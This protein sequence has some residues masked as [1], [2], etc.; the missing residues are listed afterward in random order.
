M[1]MLG[2]PDARKDRECDMEDQ[3]CFIDESH[4]DGINRSSFMEAI[5]HRLRHR[6]Q[7][8]KILGDHSTERW[9]RV[10]AMALCLIGTCLGVAEAQTV[11]LFSI[12][13]PDVSP[14]AIT[15]GPDGNL[16]FTERA[17]QIGRITPVGVISEF[18]AGITPGGGPYGITSGPDGNLWFTEY[19]GNRIGR[20]T[21]AGVVT[22]FSAGITPNSH[23]VSITTGPDG[24]L[25]FTE[26]SGRIGRI[27]PAGVV[28]EFSAGITPN[29]GLFAITAG[30]DGNLWFTEG[31][32]TGRI[33]RIT[34]AGVV[35]EFSAVITN[36]SLPYI[37]AGPD[38]NLWFTEGYNSSGIGRIT[39][40]GVVTE[41]GV[42]LTPNAGIAGIT[43]GADGNLWFTESWVGRIGQITPAGVVTEFSA[44]LPANGGPLGIATGPDGNLWFT[45]ANGNSNGG[46]SI[47]RFTIAGA[48]P[49]PTAISG[50]S[51]VSGPPGTPVVMRGVSFGAS[52]GTSILNICGVAP[53][54]SYWSDSTIAFAIPALPV[55]STCSVDIGTTLGAATSTAFQV[56]TTSGISGSVRTSSGKP[57]ANVKLTLIGPS[58]KIAQ[59]NSQ[60]A[61]L[62]SGLAQGSYNVTPSLPG[63]VFSPVSQDISVSATYATGVSFVGSAILPKIVNI[64]PG[65]AIGGTAITINGSGFGP[66]VAG[67]SQ[68]T[69]GQSPA[70]I[71]SWNDT[72]I[73]AYAPLIANPTSVLINVVVSTGLV[74][75]AEAFTYQTRMVH[76]VPESKFGNFGVLVFSKLTPQLPLSSDSVTEQ[77]EIENVTGAWYYVTVTPTTGVSG[78]DLPSG[79]FMIGPYAKRSLGTVTF[80]RKAQLSLL[81]ENSINMTAC[82]P[83]C[84][85]QTNWILLAFGGEMLFRTVFGSPL[86]TSMLDAVASGSGAIAGS[87]FSLSYDVGDAVFHLNG[88]A[89]LSI[90]GDIWKCLQDP[91]V[92]TEVTQ[93]GYTLSPD[94][95]YS[96]NWLVLWSRAA[97]ISKYLIDTYIYPHIGELDFVAK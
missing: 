52:Q 1:T 12:P 68:V 77:I 83:L 49:P 50:L 8:S 76:L 32:G 13:G 90:P 29:F 38:G 11:T 36:A 44:G 63:Y 71:V 10:L 30:P 84:G 25:W 78:P 70:S 16:W 64:S 33:G 94:L 40:T 81:A 60:G 87:L 28:T 46:N 26:E 69:F 62:S 42:G 79:F 19:D 31:S 24:N 74:S 34:P 51:P 18:S 53:Q 91:L 86:P 80:A 17:D 54:I 65:Q 7:D 41:F 73:V 55:G 47:G 3:S 66:Y 22:E 88:A 67:T 4:R 59:S 82:N 37:A 56:T 93:A 85:T 35:T 45:E 95:I 15:A 9:A 5:G 6:A 96:L 20:I 89:L 21:P 14:F 72:Q 2:R 39:T 23:P 43:T 57:L 27:T 97:V 48:A 75:N 58:P 92:Q 61:F